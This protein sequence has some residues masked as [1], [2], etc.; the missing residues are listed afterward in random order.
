[1]DTLSQ[2]HSSQAN[3]VP[4]IEI[5]LEESETYESLLDIKQ[6]ER[7]FSIF[8][9]PTEQKTTNAFDFDDFL[10][11]LQQNKAEKKIGRNHQQSA[12]EFKEML[13]KMKFPGIS[14]EEAL[15]Y[16]E[17]F[18][19]FDLDGNGAINEQELIHAMDT[20]EMN[21]TPDQVKR[22][23]QTVDVD[24]NGDVSLEEFIRLMVSIRSKN[25]F[26]SSD[27]QIKEAFSV[28]DLDRDG[29][30]GPDDLVALFVE[31]GEVIT[32]E[33]AQEMIAA[34]SK[35]KEDP[36]VGISDFIVLLKDH[37]L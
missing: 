19:I 36:K 28:V 37:D 21:M 27:S 12:L 26:I 23:I 15:Y 4:S 8:E 22:M 18:T 11:H 6:R 13:K 33:T 34:V 9:A 29:L 24:G 17:A 32:Y 20:L 1:M 7:T 10:A 30:I 2:I 3:L 14:R 5:E 25:R 31:V 16:V 35:N